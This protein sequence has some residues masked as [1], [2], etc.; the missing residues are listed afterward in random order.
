MRSGTTTPFP[1]T[2]MLPGF[3]L[4]QAEIEQYAAMRSELTERL[5]DNPESLQ[6]PFYALL[7]SGFAEDAVDEHQGGL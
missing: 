2:T 7:A 1:E 6:N 3:K 5:D 4:T